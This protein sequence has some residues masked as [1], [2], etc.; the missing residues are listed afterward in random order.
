MRYARDETGMRCEAVRGAMARCYGCDELVFPKCGA[1]IGWHWCHYSNS[2]CVQAH[3]EPETSWHMAWKN[4]VPKQYQEVTVRKNNRVKRADIK[5]ATKTVIEL[6]HSQISSGE[7]GEREDF[8]G[9]NMFWIFDS[10]GRSRRIQ[11]SSLGNDVRWNGLRQ[12]EVTLNDRV[13]GVGVVSRPSLVDLGDYVCRVIPAGTDRLNYGRRFQAVIMPAERVREAVSDTCSDSDPDVAW[14]LL[15]TKTD[16]MNKT[17]LKKDRRVRGLSKGNSIRE[18]CP[19]VGEL[20][21]RHIEWLACH[22]IKSG[23]YYSE[24]W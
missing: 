4:E 17:Q 11:S 5:A 21:E 15:D 23:G 6:Q 3:S 22:T 18:Y 13:P 7:V 12:Y 2:K 10:D 24:G 1:V 20:Q 9:R 16:W 14:F 8:Y 19:R